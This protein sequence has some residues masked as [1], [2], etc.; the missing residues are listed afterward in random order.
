MT[1]ITKSFTYFSIWH[2]FSSSLMYNFILCQAY[3][4]KISNLLHFNKKIQVAG[5]KLNK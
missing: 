5:N 1:I 2:V 3:L 4:K